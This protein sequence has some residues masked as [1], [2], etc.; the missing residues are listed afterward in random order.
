MR[1][2]EVPNLLTDGDG[3]PS[4]GPEPTV[5]V[6]GN[7][8]QLSIVKEVSVVGGG[9]ASQGATLEYVVR[10]TNISLVPALY[11]VITDDLNMPVPGYLTYV[12]DSATLNAQT[13]GIS[14]RRSGHHR[15]LLD[16]L[17]A[18]AAAA[19]CDA[20]LPR[21]H[22]SGS[23]RRHEDHEHRHGE[24]ER[25][26]ADRERQRHRSTSAPSRARAS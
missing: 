11:V 17:R 2:A 13:T 14:R 1:T 21:R 18:A 7:G 19:D 20:A 26:A 6:V 5:V 10:V 3:N 9:P 25:P 22:Q 8:Q 15:R 23:A 12:N 16:D 4:T 24:V